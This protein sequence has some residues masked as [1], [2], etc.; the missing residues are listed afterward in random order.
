VGKIDLKP[1]FESGILSIKI[2]AAINPEMVKKLIDTQEIKGI[3][4]ESLGAGNIPSRYLPVV[5]EAIKLNISV[6][7]VS[8][9]IGGSTAGAETYKLG[10]DALKAGIVVTNDMT[11][12]A[13]YV[14]LMW[15]LFQ[16]NEKIKKGEIEKKEIILNVKKMFQTDY[17]GEIML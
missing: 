13:A 16:I 12:T 10:F 15:S 14:K 4:F 17:V 1:N 9:F 3:I 2:N 6:L 5:K 8:P 11:F 7:I